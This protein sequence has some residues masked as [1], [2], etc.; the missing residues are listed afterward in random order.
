[1]KKMKIEDDEDEDDFIDNDHQVT[2]EEGY[3]SIQIGITYDKINKA[4]EIFGD[5]DEDLDKYDQ[6]KKDEEA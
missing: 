3:T 5:D 2:K 4:Q 1:M 6:I